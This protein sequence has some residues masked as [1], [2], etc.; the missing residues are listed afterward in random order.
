[1]ILQVEEKDSTCLRKSRPEGRGER[2]KKEEGRRGIGN[3]RGGGTVE[4][5]QMSAVHC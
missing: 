1:V 5:V 4:R 3:K 2:A